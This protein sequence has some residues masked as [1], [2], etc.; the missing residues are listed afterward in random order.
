M[1]ADLALSLGSTLGL[2]AAGF[3]VGWV[4][5]ALLIGGRR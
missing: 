1:L 3:V 5:N 4:A 2:L